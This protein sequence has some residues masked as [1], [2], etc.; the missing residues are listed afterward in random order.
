[1]QIVKVG[2]VEPGPGTNY[3]TAGATA[4]LAAESG[5]VFIPEGVGRCQGI[6]GL[7]FRVRAPFGERA[8]LTPW[9]ALP[10]QVPISCE[11]AVWV[12]DRAIGAAAQRHRRRPRRRYPRAVIEAPGKARFAMG[13]GYVVIGA[14][15]PAVRLAGLLAAFI[16][17]GVPR[18]GR[19]GSMGRF[20]SRD[21]RGQSRFRSRRRAGRSRL[22]REAQDLAVARPPGSAAHDDWLAARRICPSRMP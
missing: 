9:P 18:P 4:S 6:L 16:P 5:E 14:P 10:A 19:P 22:R 7:R 15:S 3:L 17:S 8:E 21:G 11:W 1:M 2:P 20:A 12:R 13:W